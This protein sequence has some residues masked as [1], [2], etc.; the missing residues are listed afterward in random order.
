MDWIGRGTAEWFGGG[1]AQLCSRPR[2]AV[3]TWDCA[4]PRSFGP[5]ALVQRVSITRLGGIRQTW[6]HSE[7]LP[8]LAGPAQSRLFCARV[9]QQHDHA[10]SESLDRITVEQVRSAVNVWL[11][12][13]DLPAAARRERFKVEL[14]EQ[15]YYQ[16]CNKQAPVSHT[17]TRIECFKAMG[18]EVDKIKSRIH[19]T[20]PP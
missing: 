5:T 17:N 10:C 13:A 20:Q 6:S 7:E 11:E 1:P 3:E 18:I 2:T 8:K 14:E 19:N 15:H 9:R 4:G 16:R 12:A